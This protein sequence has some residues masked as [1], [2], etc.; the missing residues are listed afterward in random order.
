MGKVRVFIASSIDGFIAGPHDDIA[1]LEAA[2][3]PWAPMA[4]G[5]WADSPTD[6]LGFDTFMADVG[7]ILMGRRTFDVVSAMGGDWPYGD[8]PMLVATGRPLEGAPATVTGASAPIANLVDEATR[9][10]G[11]KDIYVD[12]GSVVRQALDAELIDE[13]VVT[14]HPTVLGAGH[15]LFAGAQSRHHITVADVR[16]YGDGMVQLTLV[17]AREP[18]DERPVPDDGG[19]ADADG[20]LPNGLA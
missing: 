13:M 18:R 15:A 1:W 11:G 7:A 6:A 12:G 20:E 17:P 9:I 19:P 4:S 16:R 14:V 3:P 10:A 2:R 8:T 5:R